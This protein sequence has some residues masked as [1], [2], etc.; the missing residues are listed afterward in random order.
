[1]HALPVSALPVSALPVS[2]LP[3]KVWPRPD[4]FGP[5]LPC[6]SKQ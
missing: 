1:L 3:C 6:L 2:A 4:L 5:A